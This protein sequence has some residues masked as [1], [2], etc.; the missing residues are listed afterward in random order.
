MRSLVDRLRDNGGPWR[1]RGLTATEAEV[2]DAACIEAADEIEK[3]RA[4]VE[5][6]EKDKAR[7]DWLDS[8]NPIGCWDGWIEKGESSHAVSVWVG[9]TA[10]N[11]I[12]TV[13]AA[14]DAA[15]G[16]G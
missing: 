5:K 11:S 16:E 13:R 12:R 9:S 4:Q 3:L 8:I 2:W 6:L 7:L 14:I 1:E 10:S 15:R